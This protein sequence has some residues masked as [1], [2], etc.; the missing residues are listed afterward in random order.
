MRPAYLDLPAVYNT[1][2]RLSHGVW[3]GGQLKLG[4]GWSV[5]AS[6]ELAH[7]T[8]PLDENTVAKSNLHLLTIGAAWSGPVRGNGR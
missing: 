2:D 3:A 4:G 6:Y 8:T 7:M 1:L 5:F